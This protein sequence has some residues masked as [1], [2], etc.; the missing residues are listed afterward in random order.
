MREKTYQFGI[1]AF[2]LL[3]LANHY[4]VGVEHL[5]NKGGKS[6]LIL[7]S[8]HGKDHI[9]SGDKVMARHLTGVGKAKHFE[10]LLA[11]TIKA[12]L[13]IFSIHWLLIITIHHLVSVLFRDFSF[14]YGLVFLWYGYQLLAVEV[15]FAL[16]F[17]WNHFLIGIVQLRIVS[18]KCYFGRIKR[19]VWSRNLAELFQS[20]ETFLFCSC[21]DVNAKL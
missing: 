8:T 10:L 2:R 13:N 6:T 7:W 15:R 16:L 18:S 3:K 11:I 1:C 14:K 12:H 4:F 17:R 20:R 9:N 19:T 5:W 21:K